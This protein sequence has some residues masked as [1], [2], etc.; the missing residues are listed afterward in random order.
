MS[1]TQIEQSIQS[2]A[3]ETVAEL[4]VAPGNIAVGPDGR[5]FLSLHQA[6]QPDLNVVEL[7]GD[8]TVVPFPN[9]AWNDPPN[10]KG[11]GLNSVLGIQ[12]DQQGVAWM[13][14]NAEGVSA[15][16][17]GVP[18]VVGWNTRSNQLEQIISI[19]T[20]VARSD[21]F[22]NDLAVDN[23]HNALYLADVR[24]DQ[25]P[26]IIVVDL[27]TG[28]S[29]RVLSNHISLQP[30]A[31]APIVID[32]QE[33]RNPGPNGEPVQHRNGLN[34]ITIDPAAKWVYYGGM[35]GTSVWRVPVADL[36]NASLTDEALGERIERYGDKP[37]SDGISIDTAGNVYITDLNGKAIG[38]TQS[39]GSYKVLVQDE[40]LLW[41]DSL[42]AGPDGYMYVAVNKLHLSP[43]LNAGQNESEP[44]YY[45]MRFRAPA[46]L[47]VGR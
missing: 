14:D 6:Y 1:Q 46:D 19:P 18:R 35:N 17:G 34:P 44:P 27:E 3:L 2:I 26:A 40:Q 28:F 29:R 43:P 21:S 30:E 36:L 12:V 16:E 47:A 7:L 32:G 38:I 41:P 22:I 33:T 4:D 13:L 25:G 37:V 39:D 5:I 15:E 45:I 10:A 9:P 31:D 24:S 20:P 23:I 11:V 42:S 8:G